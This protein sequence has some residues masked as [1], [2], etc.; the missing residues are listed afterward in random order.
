MTSI[1]LSGLTL[2]A[3]AATLGTGAC[4][5]N[6]FPEVTRLDRLRILAVRALPV[7]P[8]EGETTVIEP[9]VYTT[10]DAAASTFA[11]SWCP[12]LGFSGDGYQCPVTDA[13]VA[14]LATSLGATEPPPPL[15][16]GTDPT[17]SWKNVFPADKLAAI[18]A[19]GV[20]GFNLDCDGG[21]P[22]RFK[23]TIQNGDAEVIATTVV[24]LPIDASPS[25]VNPDITGIQAIVAGAPQTIDDSAAV[26][27]PR[28]EETELRAVVDPAQSQAYPSVDVDGKP[29]TLRERLIVSWFSEQGDIDTPITA[30]IDGK[31]DLADALANLIEPRSTEED[32]AA[33]ARLIVVLRDNRG[34]VSWTTGVAK[35]GVMP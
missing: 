28:L 8:A 32:P 21:F 20:D 10:A 23:V 11:W 9:L 16:L 31:T 18:C 29:V 34:G 24:R 6:D 13:D 2:A 26:T 33:Q 17:Q 1:R 5:S 35:L 14:A 22:V 12:L 4:T 30:Y 25:N 27:L 3:L 7:N 15:E 19:M